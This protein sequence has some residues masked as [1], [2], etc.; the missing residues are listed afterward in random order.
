MF[1]L[2]TRGTFLLIEFQRRRVEEARVLVRKSGRWWE[3]VFVW[4]VS[5]L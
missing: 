2:D 3:F 5:H 4:V 1:F